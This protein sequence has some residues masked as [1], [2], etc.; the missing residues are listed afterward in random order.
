LRLDPVCHLG[1]YGGG[2][3]IPGID[4]LLGRP[5]GGLLVEPRDLLLTAKRMGEGHKNELALDI[6]AIIEIIKDIGN[7]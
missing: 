1:T 5:E 6:V 3:V 7:L 2:I 4:H